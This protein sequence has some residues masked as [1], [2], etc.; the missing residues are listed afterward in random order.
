MNEKL[1]KLTEE[2]KH[3]VDR[4]V[5]ANASARFMKKLKQVIASDK[6]KF[7]ILLDED[8]E[9]AY[10][11]E[12]KS[13]AEQYGVFCREGTFGYTLVFKCMYFSMKPFEDS[14]GESKFP[15]KSL[16]ARIKAYLKDHS[17]FE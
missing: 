1:A 14:D 10:I 13:L 7:M 6:D 12:Y 16:W 17:E 4:Q 9:A 2:I 8:H 11:R 3:E 5:M 15:N